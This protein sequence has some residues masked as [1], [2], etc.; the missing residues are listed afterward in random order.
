MNEI[1]HP[2]ALLSP[3]NRNRAIVFSIF[4]PALAAL[5]FVVGPG[6]SESRKD[7]PAHAHEVRP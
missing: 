3:F 1:A 7:P 5:S 2:S 4:A 6:V